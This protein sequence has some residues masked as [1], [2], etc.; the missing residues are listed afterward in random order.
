[1][2]LS[3]SSLNNEERKK[4][5]EKIREESRNKYL[6]D[7]H[8]KMIKR[9]EETIKET[10]KVWSEDELTKKQK[11]DLKL[12]EEVLKFEK[13]KLN[14]KNYDGYVIPNEKNKIKNDYLNKNNDN[15]DEKNNNLILI[16]EDNDFEKKQIEKAKILN[17]NKKSDKKDK[18]FDLILENNI[19]F[20][21][22][23]LKENIKEL[24][25]EEKKNQIDT[26]LLKQ[27]LV[28]RKKELSIKEVREGLPIFNLRD[29]LLELISKEQVVIVV[30]ETGSG[31]S[32]QIPQY[33]NESGYCENKKKICITQPRRVACMSVAARVSEEMNTKLGDEV[34]YSIRFE[35]C[36]SEETKIL[37][38]TDGMTLKQFLNSPD[39]EDFSVIMIDEAHER[40]LHTD[41]LFGLVKDVIRFRKDLKLIISSATI[42][43]NKFSEY[44]DDAKIFYIPGRNFNVDI[45]Y[46]K[47]SEG[48]YLDATVLTILQ[49]HLT[50]GEGDILAFLT[51]QEEIEKCEEMLRSRLE[52]Y[53][54]NDMPELIIAPIYSNLPADQQ[55]KIFETTPKNSRKVV[56]ATNIAETSLT[57]DGIVYVIDC[58]LVKQNSYNPK[59]NMESLVVVSESKNAAKQRAGRA[60]RTKEGKCFRLFT[61]EAFE[62]ELPESTVPE[63]QRTNLSNVVLLLKS[64]GINDLIHFDFMSPPPVETLLN[65]LEFLYSLGAL[66]ENGELT[67][68]GRR[69]AELP[70]DPMLS[71]MLLYSE[72][73]NCSKEILTIA[74]MLS[75]NNNIFYK[76]KDKALQFESI[77]KNFFIEGGDHLLL[78]SKIHI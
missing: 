6:I 62:N 40:S 47:A 73:L 27:K 68:L 21:T 76:P 78:L 48:D 39:L 41:I 10:K 5:M 57:I 77:Y 43:A 37:F 55:I 26:K 53:N 70:I 60:G 30:A 31:K 33:L 25:K 14:Y 63:I 72:K 74:A 16:N 75:L 9:T 3:N 42:E 1:M 36:Y 44:F 15:E 8:N 32:T 34:G 28:E 19:E 69:M 4:R 61:K 52:N 24:L 12:K 46:T 7:R 59:T 23:D 18:K 22:D 54:S 11:Q 56:I 64:L 17:N 58:G 65:S 13:E 66:N 20:I 35:D 51:G 29:E 67:K 49:I 38:M 2:I 45:Y 50:Q 71:K